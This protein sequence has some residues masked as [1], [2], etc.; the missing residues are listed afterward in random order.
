MSVKDECFSKLTCF[1]TFMVTNLQ[2]ENPGH[3]LPP[4]YY[5]QG[6][7]PFVPRKHK[8]LLINNQDTVLSAQ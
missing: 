6:Q 3:L 2:N 7:C 4:K 1:V 8:E 5:F